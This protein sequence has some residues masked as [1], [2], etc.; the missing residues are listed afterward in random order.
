MRGAEPTARRAAGSAPRVPKS[1]SLTPYDWNQSIEGLFNKRSS[2]GWAMSVAYTATEV[3]T[4]LSA[5]SQSPNDD[6]FPNLDPN[7]YTLGPWNMNNLVYTGNP[8][9]V[10][11]CA[12]PIA[13]SATRSARPT[14][15]AL[16][17]RRAR[18]APSKWFM[19]SRRPSVPIFKA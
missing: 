9:G 14:W 13:I 6:Y 3:Y 7:V 16:S 19:L 4:W 11:A 18:L 17:R 8:V 2:R 1:M 5:I 12:L 10:A 15:I